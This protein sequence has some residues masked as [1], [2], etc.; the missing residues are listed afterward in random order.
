VESCEVAGCAFV[1]CKEFE[2]DTW[3]GEAAQP[4]ELAKLGKACLFLNGRHVPILDN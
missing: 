4:C 1:G 2:A 3:K